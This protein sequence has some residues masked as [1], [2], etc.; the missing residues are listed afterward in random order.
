MKKL[1]YKISQKYQISFNENRRIKEYL[2][3]K[4]LCKVSLDW[5]LEK[6]DKNNK[7]R[8]LFAKFDYNFP[9]YFFKGQILN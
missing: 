5:I 7:I 1:L 3:E 2:N 9:L 8:L 4:L 6:S